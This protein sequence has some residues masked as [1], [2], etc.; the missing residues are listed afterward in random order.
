MCIEAVKKLLE[1]REKN[2]PDRDSICEALQIT[3][4]S[5]N[6]EFL[7]RHFTQIDGATIGGP[8]S[9]SVTDIYGAVFIDEKIVE[10]IINKEEDWKRYRDDSCSISTNT[11]AERESSKTEWMNNNIVK[12]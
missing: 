7:G 2:Y 11:T 8:E 5:N 10:N 6:C 9:A 12:D 1:T 4:S 3:M